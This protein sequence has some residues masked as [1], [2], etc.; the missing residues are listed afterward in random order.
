MTRLTLVRHGETAGQSSLRY[1]GATD[2]PLSEEGRAQMRRVRDALAAE[3][4]A[5]VY[6]S[7]LARAREG[8]AIVAGDPA[9]VRTV[10]AFDEVDFG[11]WEGWTREEI[12]ARDP[13]HYRAWQAALGTGTFHYPGGEAREAF[14]ARVVAGLGGL[15]ATAPPGHL[16]M[17]LHRG[18]IAGIL[19]AL[20]QL[21]QGARA[22]LAIDLASIHVIEAAGR[23]WRPLVLNRI[24]HLT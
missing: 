9:V 18:V 1:Y 22:G 5:A 19:S 21:P 6:S 23:G 24:D 16:L 17:V 8:A 20:L 2:V 3:R 10:A 12:A 11:R 4:F 14:D 15:L 7:R 13:E